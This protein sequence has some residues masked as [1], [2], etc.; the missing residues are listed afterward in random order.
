MKKMKFIIAGAALMALAIPSVASANVAVD[1]GVGTV[2]KGD[3]QSA[4]G[5]NDA[6]MQ[7]M[8][9]KGQVKFTAKTTEVG[10]IQ[11]S[12]SD[13]TT[14]RFTSTQVKSSP[15]NTKAETNKAGKLT[16][17][18]KLNNLSGEAG[19]V[20]SSENSGTFMLCPNGVRNSG[21]SFFSDPTTIGGLQVK[22]ID[23]PNTPVEVAP[24]A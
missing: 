16:S 9:D 5:I 8:W 22:G 10:G 4:L 20:L 11:W 7:S 18:W 12:C 14:E 23:L 6:S 17:G 21:L 19:T 1:N 15:L 13:G 2:G 24:V 3:V